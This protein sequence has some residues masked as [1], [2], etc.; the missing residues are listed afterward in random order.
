MENLFNIV[1]KTKI[2]KLKSNV[3]TTFTKFIIKMLDFILF[4]NK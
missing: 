2:K 1:I 3:S 4:I